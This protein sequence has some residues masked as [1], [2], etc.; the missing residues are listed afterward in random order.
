MKGIPHLLNPI[1]LAEKRIL[2]QAKLISRCID[3]LVQLKS[4]FTTHTGY[5]PVKNIQRKRAISHAKA[6]EVILKKGE[7]YNAYYANVLAKDDS[8][9]LAKR[10]YIFV[11]DLADAKEHVIGACS[12]DPESNSY[13]RQVGLRNW[14]WM[15]EGLI[16]PELKSYGK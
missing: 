4:N 5:G 2:D 9:G 1:D 10:N 16:V 11:I 8:G 7:T 12:Y 14:Q 6:L 15:I 3:R 13:D